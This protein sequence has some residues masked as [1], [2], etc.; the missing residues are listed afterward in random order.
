MRFRIRVGYGCVPQHF[1]LWVRPSLEAAAP[2]QR[3]PAV[4]DIHVRPHESFMNRRGWLA[5]RANPSLVCVLGE[6]L[7][8]PRRSRPGPFQGAVD[9]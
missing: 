4:E 7:L 1:R 2:V 3:R 5:L 8:G 6:R 9:R